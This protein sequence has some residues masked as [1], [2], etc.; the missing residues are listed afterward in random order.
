MHRHRRSY[1]DSYITT[2]AC[3]G[4]RAIRWRIGGQHLRAP[5][6]AEY[7]DL[8]AEPSVHVFC[9]S[10]RHVQD[11]QV[12][13]QRITHAAAQRLTAEQQKAA[14][15]QIP[16]DLKLGIAEAQVLAAQYNT[17]Q[18]LDRYGRCIAARF[19]CR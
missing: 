13:S 12:I 19:L 9:L 16:S 4:R 7:Q 17:A 5:T 18:W 10:C 2:G 11:S 15:S 1:R 3:S 6:L 14:V 8:I